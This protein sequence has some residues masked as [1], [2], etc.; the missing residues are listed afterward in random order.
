M[1]LFD[2]FRR[3]KQLE[4]LHPVFGR[5]AYQG[6]A[7]WE[8]GKATF[9]PVGHDVEVIIHAGI[10]GPSDAHLRYW[11]ELIERWPALKTACEHLLRRTLVHWIESPECGDIWSRV[12]LESLTIYPGVPPEQWELKFWCEEAGHW[13]TILMRQWTPTD[14]FVDG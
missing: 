5:I 13:P 2:I 7:T 12:D 6:D 1:G 4:A 8:L 3:A 14:C 10:D 9:P 11:R